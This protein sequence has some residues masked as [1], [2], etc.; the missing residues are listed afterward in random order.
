MNNLETTVCVTKPTGSEFTSSDTLDQSRN[1][2][3]YSV[4]EEIRVEECDVNMLTID[5]TETVINSSDESRNRLNVAKLDT[6]VRKTE[7][8]VKDETVRTHDNIDTNNTSRNRT[9][10]STLTVIYDNTRKPS[11]TRNDVADMGEQGNIGKLWTSR[12][13]E[14]EFGDKLS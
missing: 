1:R 2:E 7:S 10:K 5:L 9:Y 12:S 3:Q 14:C 11:K 8:C 4:C 6:D 13:T